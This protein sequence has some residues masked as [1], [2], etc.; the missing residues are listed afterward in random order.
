MK[1]YVSLRQ[2]TY[3]QSFILPQG[4]K[5]YTD[6]V[7]ASVNKFHVWLYVGFLFGR[8]NIYS[9]SLSPLYLFSWNSFVPLYQINNVE[10]F[11]IYLIHGIKGKHWTLKKL[12]AVIN[13][14]G[15]PCL[16]DILSSMPAIVCCIFHPS[17]LSL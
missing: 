9:F 12:N 10:I 15:F 4:T 1:N 11:T 14:A 5:F 16:T 6:N 3:D 17:E 2:T 8:C 7:R 13:P